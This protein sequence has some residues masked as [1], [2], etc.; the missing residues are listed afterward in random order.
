MQMVYFWLTRVTHESLNKDI[1]DIS[2]KTKRPG[3]I[4][5]AD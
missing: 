5:F 4:T 1:F 2:I 3:K